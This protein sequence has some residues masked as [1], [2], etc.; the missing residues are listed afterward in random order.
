MRGPVR[1][2]YCFVFP[3]AQRW[4]VRA[5]TLAVKTMGFRRIVSTLRH[6]KGDV[7]VYVLDRKLVREGTETRAEST[8]G[9]YVLS[10]ELRP[11]CLATL[12]E[13]T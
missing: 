1:V 3:A 2:V 11:E 8:S 12:S 7:G 6:P 5:A 10:G 9:L 13:G 4:T